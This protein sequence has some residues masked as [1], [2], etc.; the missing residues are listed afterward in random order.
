MNWMKIYFT[1]VIND[2]IYEWMTV[3]RFQSDVIKSII[4][5]IIILHIIE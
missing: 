4:I 1:L 3:C 2:F 5:I